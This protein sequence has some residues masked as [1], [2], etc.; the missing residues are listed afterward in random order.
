MLRLLTRQGVGTFGRRPRCRR[1]S[2]S[3]SESKPTRRTSTN[4]RSFKLRMPC[5]DS[6]SV[7]VGD[8]LG[9]A[10]DGLGRWSASAAS[11]S[12]NASASDQRVRSS[13]ALIFENGSCSANGSASGF[14]GNGVMPHSSSPTSGRAVVGMFS[15]GY[16]YLLNHTH[17]P[18]S[19]YT[20]HTRSA[21]VWCVFP[22][23]TNRLLAPRAAPRRRPPRSRSLDPRVNQDGSL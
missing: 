10:F 14:V 20:L 11:S 2:C 4:V 22:Q 18:F 15:I 1:T 5:S 21:F 13:S 16:Q 7:G 8:R 3:P 19:L 17:E 12:W 23:H 6:S 9:R